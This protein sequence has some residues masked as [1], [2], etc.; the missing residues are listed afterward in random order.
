VYTI[1][2]LEG[3]E[4]VI[5]KIVT[6]CLKCST[7]KAQTTTTT[8]TATY[9]PSEKETK[10]IKSVGEKPKESAPFASEKP[11]STQTIIKT[12]TKVSSGFT[13]IETVSSVSSGGEKVE[14]TL[15]TG[16]SNPPIVPIQPSVTTIAQVNAANLMSIGAG[17]VAGLTGILGVLLMI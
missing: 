16:A 4:E 3:D 14:T 11:K 13:Y 8:Y 9:S 17:F 12:V 7:K 1:T 15:H 5:T 2:K 10:T 6:D